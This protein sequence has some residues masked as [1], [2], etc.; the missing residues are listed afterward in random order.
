LADFMTTDRLS[1][2]FHLNLSFRHSPVNRIDTRCGF[3]GALLKSWS[4]S[5][6]NPL[7]VAAV[8]VVAISALASRAAVAWD[9]PRSVLESVLLGNSPSI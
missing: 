6:L 5:C 1:S 2:G 4:V 7:L 8:V 9:K 3:E